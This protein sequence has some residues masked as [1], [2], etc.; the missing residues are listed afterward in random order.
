VY[1]IWSQDKDSQNGGTVHRYK[2][3]TLAID[4][5]GE[6]LQQTKYFIYLGGKI[7][8]T[9]DSS[10]DVNRHIGLASGVARILRTVWK[11]RD[12]SRM[13]KIR[14]YNSL[15]LAVLLYNLETW[16][17]KAVQNRKLPVFTNEFSQTHYGCITK[18]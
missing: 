15:V 4:I 18:G 10:A 2:E 11:S 7:S 8:D 1:E 5:N 16:T 14:L 12:I 9:S 17:L 3:Q 13:T 6:Q